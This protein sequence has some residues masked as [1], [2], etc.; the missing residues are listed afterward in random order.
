MS[1]PC[2]ANDRR[3]RN[4]FSPVKKART[5]S[6]FTLI[7]LLVTVAIT[8]V[9]A[10]LVL[11]SVHGART[12]AQQLSAA[13]NV[14]N[15][16]QAVLTFSLDNDGNLPGPCLVGVRSVFGP[17]DKALPRYVSPYLT[18]IAVSPTL[19][20]VPVLTPPL[21]MK[22]ASATEGVLGY[23]LATKGFTDPDYTYPFGRTK[24]STDAEVSPKKMMSIPS[25]S[26]NVMLFEVD[27]ENIKTTVTWKEIAPP[28]PIYG[29]NRIHLFF[30]GHVELKSLE[31]SN[32]L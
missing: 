30:D 27:R 25:P 22:Y 3:S 16:H 15:V 5:Q 21:A 2:F 4:G 14:R 12:R 23:G 31:D 32:T 8:G 6:A 9:L 10:A 26:K 29:G 7:E 24:G 18:T 20:Q 19:S 1:S 28:K 11:S 17:S 13:A